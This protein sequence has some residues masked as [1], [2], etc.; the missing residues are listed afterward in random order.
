VYDYIL[1]L[2]PFSG[3]S[4]CVFVQQ[5][6]K[7]IKESVGDQEFSFNTS[8]ETYASQLTSE[9]ACLSILGEGI[10]N[11]RIVYFTKEMQQTTKHTYSFKFNK[12]A[13]KDYTS[14]EGV[15]KQRGLAHY[16]KKG[17]SDF[18][19]LID[20]DDE[21]KFEK[22]RELL[23]KYL[24]IGEANQADKKENKSTYTV[25]LEQMKQIFTNAKE[26]NLKPVIEILNQYMSDFNINTPQR[27]V[28]FIAQVGHES[29]EFNNTL[30]AESCAYSED[31]IKEIFCIKPRVKINGIVYKKY[32][33]LFVDYGCDDI[34]FCNCKNH[35]CGKKILI[36]ENNDLLKIKNKYIRSCMLFDYVYSLRMGNNDV[37]SKDGSNYRGRGILQLT[38]KGAY[39]DFNNWYNKNYPTDHID[40]ISN[41]D[42]ILTD[43]KYAVLSALWEYSI[44]KKEINSLADNDNGLQIGKLINGSGKSIPNGQLNR[45]E[46]LKKA[47]IVFSIN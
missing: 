3:E 34:T 23:K 36:S 8:K 14:K 31:R 40:L 43:I 29:G 38:G 45:S 37:N 39:S 11:T 4:P 9:T 30:K 20:E 19:I 15:I 5:A 6:L 12:Q 17:I 44:N 33:D 41:P 2:N 1:K 16:N 21:V 24:G 7:Q 22:Q 35:P 13:L 26:E 10:K 32:G 25:S 42:L 47:K 27:F 18:M 46:I 28:H